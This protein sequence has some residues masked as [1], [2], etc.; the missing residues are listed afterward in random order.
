VSVSEKAIN[1][2]VEYVRPLGKVVLVGLPLD[3]KLLPLF[4]MLLLNQLKL[5][6]LML[7]TERILKK[8]WI[9]LLEVKSIVKSRLLVLVNYQKFSN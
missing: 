9:S 2:S 7:V 6:V 3:P 5:K 4:S 1:Q 8:L